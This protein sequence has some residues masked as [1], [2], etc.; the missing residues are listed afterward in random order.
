PA[1]A[2]EPDRE[3]AEALARLAGAL[4]ARPKVGIRVHGVA[5][6]AADRDALAAAQIELHVTLATAGADAI[7]RP[8]PVDFDS[9][10]HRD[11]LD[12]FAGERLGAERRE[13]IASYFT[14]DASGAVIDAERSDYYRALFDALVESETI[15]RS[16]LER[17]AR[18]RARSIA[19]ALE[20]HGV[21]A[22][23]IEI[24]PPVVRATDERD[25][26]VDEAPLVSSTLEAFLAS[27]AA[28]A[29]S[30]GVVFN[31]ADHD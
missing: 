5:E 12:E 4:V 22:E 2:A 1:G 14:R 27:D 18:Y 21:A 17:L 19:D 24:A 15:P 31:V 13:T 20:R 29:R 9:P 10:R 11:V 30:A 23:R 16:A 26:G 28:L 3:G 8:R 7:A 6:Q 25:G